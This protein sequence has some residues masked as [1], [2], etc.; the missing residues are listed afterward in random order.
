SAVDLSTLDGTTG[1]RLDGIDA[2]GYSGRSVSSAGDVNGD[3][4]DDLIIGANFA[5][6]ERGESYVVFGISSTSEFSLTDAELAN[7]FT[8]NRIVVGAANSGDVTFTAPISLLSSNTL[9]IITGGTVNDTGSTTVFTGTNFAITAAQGI[10]TTS[11]LDT[12]VSNFV[13]DGGSGGVNVSNVG[14]LTI[15]GV[16]SPVFGV[17]ATSGDISLNATAALTVDENVTNL[18]TGTVSLDAED[19]ILLTHGVSTD[20]GAVTINADSNSD[21]NGSLVQQALVITNPVT[22]FPGT[23][24]LSQADIPAGLYDGGSPTFLDDFEDG[25]LDGG[26]VASDGFVQAAS[27]SSDSVDGDGVSIDGVGTL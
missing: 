2:Y 22:F 7:V 12:A 4:I 23:S 1:F 25:T 24:Y 15:G 9:E 19:G 3:G 10:G 16:P 14:A 5:N 13:A 8:T 6:G 21:G 20:S 17:S 11:S 18:G 26:I 27:P